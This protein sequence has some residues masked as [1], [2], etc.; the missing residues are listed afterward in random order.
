MPRQADYILTRLLL[1][2]SWN[3]VKLT[4]MGMNGTPI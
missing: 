1:D 2:F 4:D 3:Y